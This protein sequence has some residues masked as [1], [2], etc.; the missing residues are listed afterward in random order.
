MD[1]RRLSFVFSL[2]YDGYGDGDGGDM[3]FLMMVVVHGVLFDGNSGW[4]G[5]YRCCEGW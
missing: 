4:V 3:V 1:Y 5:L 2:A